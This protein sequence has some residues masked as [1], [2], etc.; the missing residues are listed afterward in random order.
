MPIYTAQQDFPAKV[1]AISLRSWTRMG[2]FAP[3]LT[4][5]I[6]YH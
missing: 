6:L 2:A 1:G 4:A 5:V 3:R